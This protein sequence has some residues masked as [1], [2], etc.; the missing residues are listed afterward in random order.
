MGHVSLVPGQDSATGEL[1]A[2]AGLEGKGLLH[3]TCKGLL[4][5]TVPKKLEAH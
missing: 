3:N 1:R 5:Y 4:S 2:R